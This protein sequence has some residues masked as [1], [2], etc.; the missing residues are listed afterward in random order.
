MG[1][2]EYSV[3]SFITI[4]ICRRLWCWRQ[5]SQ[6]SGGRGLQRH[7]GRQRRHTGLQLQ[8]QQR[9]LAGGHYTAVIHAA[10]G[11]GPYSFRS[12]SITDE[13]GLPY[14][15]S[16]QSNGTLTGVGDNSTGSQQAGTYTFTVEASDHAGRTA[17][18][19]LI[20]VIEDLPK[21]PPLHFVTTQLPDAMAGWNYSSKLIVGGVQGNVTFSMSGQPSWLQLSADGTLSGTPTTTGIH[22]FTVQA[23]DELYESGTATF[24]TTSATF[25]IKPTDYQPAL[26]TVVS[27]NHQNGVPGQMLPMPLLVRVT[28]N[29]MPVAG[30]TVT[31]G[32]IALP[33]NANGIASTEWR[34]P[35]VEGGFQVPVTSGAGSALF[36]AWAIKPRGGHDSSLPGLDFNTIAGAPPAANIHNILADDAEVSVESRFV[37]ENGGQ[38]EAQYSQHVY[39]MADQGN[40]LIMLH[41]SGLPPYTQTSK[42][43]S[44]S[45]GTSGSEREAPVPLLTQLTQWVN[46]VI[47]GY[48][49][50]GKD[51]ESGPI[52]GGP[53][54]LVGFGDGLPDVNHLLQ[55]SGTFLDVGWYGRAQGVYQRTTAEV[56]LKRKAPLPTAP[57]PE[58]R[59]AFL[60]VTYETDANGVETPTQT[61]V[62]YLTMSPSENE[63]QPLPLSPEA[64]APGKSKRLRLL[65]VDLDVAKISHNA[66]LGELDDSKKESTGAFV[67][68]N[69]DDDDYSATSTSLGSDKDQP[70]AIIGENDLL[71]IYLKKLPQL[72]GAKFLLDIP[73]KTKVWKNSNRQ[74]E[75]TSTTEFDA[76]VDTT[77]YAEGVSKGSDLLKLILRHGG[78]DK[79]D[80][81]RLKI[82]VFEL[83][84]V[85]NV[86]GYTAYSYT[87]DGSLPTGSKWGTPT[88][89][90]VKSG[91][92]PTQATIL[93]DQGPVVGKA[94]YEVNSDY[95]WELEV[96]VVQVKLGTGASNK[97]V[98]RQ[99]LIQNSRLISSSASGRA[100]EASLTIDKVIG[101][102]VSGSTRGEQFLEL[103]FI[104]NGQFTRKHALYNGF[105]PK[106]RR[107]SSLQD[108]AF[109]IDYLT[110]PPASTAPWYDSNSTTGLL[111]N[112]P[113]GGITGHALNVSDTP[114][115][116]ATDSMSLTVGTVS[117]MADKF[118]IEFDFNLYLAVRTLQDV[119]GSK[120][121]YTQRG[122]ASWEFDGS[123]DINASGVWTQT[124]TGNTGSASLTEITNG[125][126]VPI[127]TG[128]PLNSLFGTQTWTT[129]N[130]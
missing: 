52:E 100:M 44:T 117:D 113:S 105:T 8:C 27:G 83:K 57:L 96:N 87:A 94:V 23:R 53:A 82:T 12:I 56:R 39:K 1:A 120:D 99:G 130:Q 9:C 42:N 119:N 66:A 34:C 93:W 15:Y 7:S 36:Q 19:T 84:G 32:D 85:L 71:P 73:S 74:D 91:S 70:V 103:G 46:G 126:T 13:T 47:D 106:Q 59:R 37:S 104:Q 111:K 55:E 28:L 68:L 54:D 62:K 123:G 43:W 6:R 107:R 18:K 118:G 16:L 102:S 5:C 81:A 79:A 14:G 64:P 89:G 48:H 75:V 90:S 112:I 77:V 60:L 101:P 92:T 69:S 3:C 17:I 51:T 61:E 10:R 4:R 88:G 86:P 2:N 98:Y 108:G 116:S 122:K 67:P 40:D 58:I 76:S 97:I 80:I 50:S 65:P 121:L 128:T 78:Q 72:T 33:A 45:D 49:F 31:F 124:G 115:V 35:T 109:H 41:Q 127:T 63:S 95:V 114:N 110:D 30:A 21:P 38:I 20:L 125:D 11:T 22:Y 24:R 25:T 26:V 29:G 129:E